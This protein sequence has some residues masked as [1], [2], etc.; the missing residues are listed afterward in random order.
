MEASTIAPTITINPIA[1]T[2]IQKV[3][4]RRLYRLVLLL[5]PDFSSGG[6]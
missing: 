3:R 6:M 2:V 5:L 1:I 4:I